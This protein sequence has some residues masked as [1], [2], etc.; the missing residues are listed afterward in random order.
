M[1]VPSDG[2]IHYRNSR[3]MI[4]KYAFK[5]SKLE[6]SKYNRRAN[7]PEKWYDSFQRSKNTKPGKPYRITPIP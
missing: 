4:A 5:S 6:V 3:A 2:M 1:Y 7:A